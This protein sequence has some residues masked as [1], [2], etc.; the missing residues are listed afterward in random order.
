MY[1]DHCATAV[2]IANTVPEPFRADAFREVLRHL[3]SSSGAARPSGVIATQQQGSAQVILANPGSG[4]G[5]SLVEFVRSINPSSGPEHVVAIG[6]YVEQTTSHGFS[7]SDIRDGLIAAKVK[8]ANPSDALSKARGRGL[9][10]ESS[11]K[12]TF[13]LTRSAEEWIAER[14]QKSA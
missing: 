13:V 9:I 10:M 1:E 3:L 6:A 7:S 11:D 8:L 14:L 5:I 12:G 2:S 4:K